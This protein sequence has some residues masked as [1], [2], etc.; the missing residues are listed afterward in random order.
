MNAASRA[1]PAGCAPLGLAVALGLLLQTTALAAPVVSGPPERVFDWEQARCAKWDIPD[2]PAR[3][4]RGADGRVHLIAGSDQSRLST[5]A[6]LDKLERDCD[7]VHAGAE[8]DDPAA[9]DDR[10]WIAAVFTQDGVRIEALAHVEYHGHLRPER[11][12]AGQYARCWRNAVVAVVSSDGGESFSATAPGAGTVAVL[13]YRYDGE[14]SGREGYFNPSNI[15]RHGN[16]LYAFVFAEALDAQ[17]R[18]PCLL[19]R[20]VAGGSRDW[21][22]WDGRGFTRVFADPYRTDLTDPGRHTCVPVKGIGSTVSSVVRH[23]PSGDFLA[24]T[25]S[26]RPGSDGAPQSGI[27][28]MRSTDLVH[29]SEPALLVELPLLWRRDCAAPAAYAYPSL[30]DGDSGSRNFDTVD[31]DFWL[32]LVEMR[33]GP[34]CRIGPDRDLLRL[35]VTWP[36]R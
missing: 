14:K 2:A 6:T 24:V 23:L 26:T 13:P 4:W 12:A 9:Y 35:P 34:D 3:A 8:A 33:I 11:C 16:H 25:P 36:A 7:V 19:R 22:A 17:R 28:W 32:Y 30:L 18:G 31:A 15:L 10:A 27:Y 29:W 21:R 5:G 1:S 20:P